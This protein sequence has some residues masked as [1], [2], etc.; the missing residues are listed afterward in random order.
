MLFIYQKTCMCSVCELYLK[1]WTH[2]L[3][4]ELVHVLWVKYNKPCQII[5]GVAWAIGGFPHEYCTY[6]KWKLV[7]GL[8]MDERS[9][10]M[11]LL[12]H[13]ILMHLRQICKCIFYFLH[14]CDCFMRIF[15]TACTQFN[16]L[17]SIA[18][19]FCIYNKYQL[20]CFDL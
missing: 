13:H 16:M 11:A 2:E 17:Q 19:S 18:V 8:R 5:C 14:V 15:L 7:N 4:A 1:H 10:D 6:Q 12:F 9:H 20:F 3:L